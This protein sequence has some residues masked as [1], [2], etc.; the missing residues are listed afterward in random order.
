MK[1]IQTNTHSCK[2]KGVCP[3]GRRNFCSLLT[4]TNVVPSNASYWK[5]CYT[6]YNLSKPALG[7]QKISIVATKSVILGNEL[8]KELSVRPFGPILSFIFIVMW[9]CYIV[10]FDPFQN[11]PSFLCIHCISLL[12]T[13]WEKER[14]LVMSH[15]SISQCFLPVLDH[16]HFIKF[17]LVVCKLF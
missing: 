15:F 10:R 7:T 2:A 1:H 4:K 14:L 13:S 6:S 9:V 5:W 3:K 11:K 12:E 16:R 8:L 17:K